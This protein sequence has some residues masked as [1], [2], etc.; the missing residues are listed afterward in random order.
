MP[1]TAT[2]SA[3]GKLRPLRGEAANT[4]RTGCSP[5]PASEEGRACAQDD[6]RAPTLLS[7]P[8]DCS[9]VMCARSSATL[10]L[11]MHYLGERQTCRVL[12]VSISAVST[13]RSIRRTAA[14]RLAPRLNFANTV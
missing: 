4:L 3:A 7:C 14:A 11:R 2:C 6:D 8:F 9:P 12:R 10:I 13:G 5:S 1:P